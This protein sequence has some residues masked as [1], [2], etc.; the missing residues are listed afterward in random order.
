M[1]TLMAVAACAI[2]AARGCSSLDRSAPVFELAAVEH[3]ALLL[4]AW[5]P[6]HSSGPTSLHGKGC[7][8]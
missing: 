5:C 7:P 2:A 8:L 3:A 1:D 6:C 4:D